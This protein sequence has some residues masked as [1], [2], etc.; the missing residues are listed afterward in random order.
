MEF[1][2]NGNLK[3][4]SISGQ[5][6][7]SFL[8]KL[9]NQWY[10]SDI[11]KVSVRLFDS[12]LNYLTGRQATICHMNNNCNQYLV[13]EHNGDVYPCDFFV[14]EDLKLGNINNNSWEELLNFPA[15]NNFGKEKSCYSFLC[16]S[17]EYL[18][19]CYGDCLK[20]RNYTPS[21]SSEL[22]SLCSG[23]KM[24]YKYIIKD[25]GNI[26]KGIIFN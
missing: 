21:S 16:N 10:P 19:Y 13:V 18:K 15:Y 7:G 17:C 4:F 9:F 8:I 6:W 23:W 12:I 20:Y 2:K 24:F 11:Y 22:S 3:P 1:D 14:R 5:Q 26:A 25:F